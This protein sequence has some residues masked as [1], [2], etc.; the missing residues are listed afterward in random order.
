MVRCSQVVS[1]PEH[2]L[3]QKEITPTEESEKETKM[4][5]QVKCKATEK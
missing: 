2:W 5:K 3:E 1:H 4:I